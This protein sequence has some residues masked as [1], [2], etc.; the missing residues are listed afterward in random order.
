M[1]FIELSTPDVVT[2]TRY[3]YG[4]SCRA[5]MEVTN[6]HATHNVAFK[7]K[8]TAPKIFVVKPTNGILVP[9]Q[10]MKC[11][12]QLLVTQISD[13]EAAKNKFMV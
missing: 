3:E 12:V 11:K 10:T 6:A 8:S 4:G 5:I 9:G 13:R 2:L 7:L 1:A